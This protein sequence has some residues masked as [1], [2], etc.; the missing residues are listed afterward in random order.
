MPDAADTA[1]ERETTPS[2]VPYAR[3]D[4]AALDRGAR[5]GAASTAAARPLRLWVVLPV[6][7]ALC[8]FQ[9]LVTILAANF[10]DI[11]LTSTMIPVLTFGGLFA[12][13]LVVNPAVRLLGRGR[14]A[15]LGRAELVAIFAA[16]LVTS[17]IST[18]GL[19]AQLVPMVGTPWNPEWNTPQR[20]WSRQVLPKLRR[21]L[22]LDACSE[23]A[24]FRIT[25]DAPAVM[26][27]DAIVDDTRQLIAASLTVA[28][29][30][31]EIDPDLPVDALA[32]MLA[33]ALKEAGVMIA[34]ADDPARARAQASAGARRL[35]AGLTG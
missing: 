31:G 27:W 9:A 12:L 6:S 23:P 22:Y 32:R 28:R 11:F 29:A 25:A 3:V 21:E 5:E 24:F 10:R 8:L 14:L 17:G 20:G 1:A 35:L 18:F 16:M 7:I 2:G 33:A 26:G 34:T 19:T 13:V 30:G 4:F 15:A